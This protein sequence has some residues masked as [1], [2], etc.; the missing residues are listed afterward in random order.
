MTTK[1]KTEVMLAADRGESIE[2]ARIASGDDSWMPCKTPTWNWDSFVY[3]VK[4][5]EP[6][7]IFVNEYDR[8]L[9]VSVALTEDDARSNGGAARL[10]TIE[11]VEVLK[12]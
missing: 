11:F 4:P 1:Q 9:G 3:R 10:R 2:F 6:R 8:G 5:R 7:R 12:P